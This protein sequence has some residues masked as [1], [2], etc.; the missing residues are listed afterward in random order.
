MQA[1]L[2]SSVR[3]VAPQRASRRSANSQQRQQARR[4]LAVRAAGDFVPSQAVDPEVSGK[5]SGAASFS[6][7]AAVGSWRPASSRAMDQPQNHM[8]VATG[9][10]GSDRHWPEVQRRRQLGAGAGAT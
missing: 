3:A 7:A 10:Q 8:S 5:A 4:Q 1:A 2:A 9:R 6:A